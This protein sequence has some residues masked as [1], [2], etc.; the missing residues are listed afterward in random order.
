MTFRASS[1]EGLCAR[2]D[3]EVNIV[4]LSI[5]IFSW[6]KILLSTQGKK[7]RLNHKKRGKGCLRFGGIIN[8]GDALEN[9]H[10]VSFMCTFTCRTILAMPLKQVFL[11][12]AAEHQRKEKLSQGIP[13]PSAM[14]RWRDQYSSTEIPSCEGSSTTSPCF[15]PQPWPHT[16]PTAAQHKSASFLTP[17]FNGNPFVLRVDELRLQ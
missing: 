2:K 4:F 11:I 13:H 14:S 16:G 8:T 1:E 15:S 3:M 10:V 12:G 17:S 5:T 6:S 9:F 7:I